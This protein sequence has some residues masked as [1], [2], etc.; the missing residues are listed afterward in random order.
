MSPSS[1]SAKSE[2][3]HLCAEINES[4]DKGPSFEDVLSMIIEDVLGEASMPTEAT[5]TR[6]NRILRPVSHDSTPH[7]IAPSRR[8]P[9]GLRALR[10]T[11]PT[12]KLNRGRPLRA[13]HLPF[14]RFTRPRRSL[15]KRGHR[16][17][18]SE[19]DDFLD[20]L[21]VSG[22]YNGKDLVIKLG[23]DLSKA[24]VA[25]LSTIITKPLELLNDVNF[26]KELGI[27]EGTPSQTAF[28]FASEISFSGGA[29]VEAVGKKSL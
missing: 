5:S 1:T 4:G 11:H 6:R 25:N 28:D 12:S 17:L 8:H 9:R 20:L 16:R 24:A 27:F 7:P 15:Q 18:E 14:T 29:H 21:S 22:G 13:H 10:A 19:A 23:I 3:F 26:V 2:L